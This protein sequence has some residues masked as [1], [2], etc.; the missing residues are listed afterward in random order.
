MKDVIY[1]TISGPTPPAPLPF[2]KE[3]GGLHCFR[4]INGNHLS[5][6]MW[7]FI[8]INHVTSSQAAPPSFEKGRGPGGWVRVIFN[9][10]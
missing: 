8:N 6:F 1:I 5:F 7:S 3:G 10:T 9:L 2:S 4:D